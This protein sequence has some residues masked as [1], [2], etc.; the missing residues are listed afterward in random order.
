MRQTIFLLLLSCSTVFTFGQTDT[1]N[2]INSK[3]LRTGYWIGYYPDGTKRYETRF[4]DGIIIHEMKRYY[5]DGSIKA[6][7]TRKAPGSLFSAKLFDHS[8]TL[9]ADGFYEEQK[10][11]GDWKFYGTEKNIVLSI[12]YDNDKLNGFAHKYYVNG[13]IEEKT[14]WKNNVLHGQQILYNQ[15]GVITAIINYH[16]GKVDGSYVVYYPNG[17]TEIS[18]QYTGNL[19][20]GI[21]KYFNPDGS[22]HYQL[23]YDNGTLLNPE[24]LTKEQEQSFKDYENNRTLLKDPSRYLHDPVSYFKK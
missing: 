16:S 2:Q 21:W 15:D 4:L 12:T 22:L 8:G 13:N 24:V 6:I 14:Q 18:G 17:K 11:T 19:K 20:T 3:G 9:R 7:L 1:I 5:P 23:T 10:K